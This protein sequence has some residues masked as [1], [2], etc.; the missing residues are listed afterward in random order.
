VSP[1]LEKEQS[2]QFDVSKTDLDQ[3][4]SNINAFFAKLLLARLDGRMAR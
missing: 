1:V 2:L 4:A 3:T